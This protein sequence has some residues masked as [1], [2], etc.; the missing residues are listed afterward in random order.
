MAEVA[1]KKGNASF[2]NI[3]A[4]TRSWN[5]DDGVTTIDVTDFADVGQMKHLAGLLDWTVTVEGNWEE[6]NTAA[7]GDEGELVLT[8]TG[9][10]AY[11]GN[12]IMTGR[13]PSTSVDDAARITYTFQGNGALGTTGF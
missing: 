3:T 2:P 6:V 9:S 11:F 10:I 8:I 5:I 1:G 4:G 13:T 12:A 7:P